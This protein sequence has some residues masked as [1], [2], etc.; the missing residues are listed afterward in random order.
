MSLELEKHFFK[1]LFGI[2]ASVIAIYVIFL[3]ILVL[4]QRHLMYFP[5]GQDFQPAKLGLSGFIRMD[6]SAPDGIRLHGFYAP[7][8]AGRRL[9][10]L[11]LQGNAGNLNMRADK[12]RL[13]QKEGF[14]LMLA[15][16][17]GYAGNRGS[18]TEPGLYQDARAAITTLQAAGI[19]RKDM[20]IYGESLG[21]GLAVQMASEGPSA[22]LILEAPYTS[23]PDVGQFRY[24][25]VPIFWVMQDKFMSIAK[26][27]NIHTPLLVL[28]AGQDYV[29]PPHFARKLYEAANSPKQILT[30]ATAGHNTIYSSDEVVAGILSFMDG[31]ERQRP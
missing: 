18:P 21:T 9:T 29:I 23:I 17:R 14:G 30:N 10:I 26:I 20:I 1:R 13:W 2:L 16:Y 11:F 28:Q 24:P 3:A 4:F 25:F 22:A 19:A 15:T 12:I 5:D 8:A 6:Y 31:V 7:R 27:G